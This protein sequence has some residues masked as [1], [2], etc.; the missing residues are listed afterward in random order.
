M[1]KISKKLKL[2]IITSLLINSACAQFSDIIIID[3]LSNRTS[4]ICTGDV[5]NDGLLDILLAKRFNERTIS[6]YLNEGNGNFGNEQIIAGSGTSYAYSRVASADLN[7]DSYDDVVTFVPDAVTGSQISLAWFA[8]DLG[9][10][11]EPVVLD[12]G[13]SVLG[14]EE[15]IICVDIDNDNDIDIII[16]DDLSIRVYKND[17][18]G[19]FTAPNIIASSDEYY[20]IDVCDYNGD[21]FKDIISLGSDIIVFLND[22]SGGF[23]QQSIIS[24]VPG[25]LYFQ[26]TSADFDNDG[27]NDF[28]L[29]K[30]NISIMWFANDG[31]G[32]VFTFVQELTSNASNC[33]S[34]VSSDV[35]LDGDID[36]VTTFDQIKTVVWFENLGSG[37]FSSE[38]IIYQT[39]DYIGLEQ[40]NVADLDNDGDE[41][42]IWGATQ[43]PLAFHENLTNTTSV[44]ENIGNNKIGILIYPNPAKD[45]INIKSEETIENV[46]VYDHLWQ[47]VTH[48]KVNDKTLQLTTAE[49]IKGIYLIQIQ[50]NKHI[51]LK[52]FI[53]N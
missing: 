23:P 8:N 53:K 2:I 18:N 14:V 45:F 39:S 11:D 3:S 25:G 38:N 5:N 9:V 34:L 16:D 22:T 41:E 51:I 37:A 47:P 7:S 52:K 17:G 12:S 44:V 50:L 31:T 20:N 10:F 21:G 42:I 29:W 43:A 15:E 26:V 19:N 30:S 49:W 4:D 28:A 33:Y 32:T 24:G 48:H 46:S 36:I 6:Y 1:K 35:D 40:L 27:D 13:L